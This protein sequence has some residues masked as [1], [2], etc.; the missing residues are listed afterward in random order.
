MKIKLL[1][2]LFLVSFSSF[3]Q[4]TLIPDVNFEKKL[5][6]LGIDSGTADGRVLTA[7]ISSLTS[8]DVSSSFIT[9]LTGIQDFVALTTLNCYSNQLSN[10]DFSNNTAL[11]ELHCDRNQLTNLD[12]SQNTALTVLYC[13]NNQLA[14]LDVSKNTAL[15]ELHCTINKFTNLDV[16][17]NIALAVLYCDLNQLT[18]LNVSNNT[19]LRELSCSRN[20]L[21]NLDVSNNI[22]LIK[23]YCY[24]NQLKNLDVSKNKVLTN[25]QCYSN[26]LRSL[27]LKNG[28]NVNMISTFVDFT[29]NQ[30]LACIQVDDIAY[31]NTNWATLKDVKASYTYEN[32]LPHH[33]VISNEFEDK[34]IGLGID[35][36]GK[37]GYVLTSSVDKITTLDISSSSITDLTGIQSFLALKTLD[38]SSN[39]LT[40]LDVSKNV[41]LNTLRC[42]FNQIINLDV[43][44]NIGL[45]SLTCQSN[46]LTTLD[47]SKN[48]GLTGLNCRSNLLTNLDISKNV[49]LMTLYCQS[50]QLTSLNLK[51]GNNNKFL[52]L[53]FKTNP[54]LSCIQVDDEA[55][56]NTNWATAKDAT[57]SYSTNCPSPYVVISNEFEDKLITLGI[58]KDGKNGSV[59]LADITDVKSIDVSNSGITNL[60]GIEYFTALETLI[61]KGNSLTTINVSHSLALKYL[62]CSKNPLS[63]LDVTKNKQLTEL[64]CDGIV[65]VNKKSNSKTATGS[66]TVLDVS[67]NLLLTKLDCSNNQIVSLNL[68]QNTLLTDIDCS[69]NRL[70]SLNVNNGNNSKLIN[71]NFKTNASLTCIKVDDDIYANASWS[72]AKDVTA[73]YSKTACTLGIAETV[74]ETIEVYPNPTKGEVHIDNAILEKVTVYDALG[75]LVKMTTFAEG[76]TNNTINLAGL[77]SG[78]YYVYLQNE[79]STIVK[80][81]IVE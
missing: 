50:N 27:N 79:E 39:Q 73:S 42:S 12:V 19:A 41:A 70:T 32:C 16:S 7:N 53:D 40:N 56:S 59:L 63:V 21:I 43:S 52:N 46:Q 54:N 81:I 44:M 4:Y 2:L 74:F 29:K 26:L 65:T 6:A 76:S 25:L 5:I 15:N 31:S 24:S 78:V 36:D 35:T 77:P 80:K 11:R 8:L 67:N 75:K 61:C 30:D 18:N 1:S 49:G 9:D 69:N 23:L 55:Y 57:A 71:V 38:C 66:L 62:D 64:Y 45:K 13:Y 22:A 3:A 48:T 47:V 28:N 34:L 60:S 33:V 20:Q 37:N 58:D 72:S 14:N 68:S 17:N 51:N 10:L